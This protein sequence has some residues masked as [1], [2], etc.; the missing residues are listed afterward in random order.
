MEVHEVAADVPMPKGIGGATSGSAMQHNVLIAD[1]IKGHDITN[2][3]SPSCVTT[4][5]AEMGLTPGYALDITTTDD[6]GKHWGLSKPSKQRKA[7][8]FMGEAS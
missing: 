6:K 2:I 8:E 3:Y 7:T 1:I 5:A 4:T